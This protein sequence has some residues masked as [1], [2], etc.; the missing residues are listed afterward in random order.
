MHPF[1]LVLPPMV[2]HLDAVDVGLHADRLVPR[3]RHV[4]VRQLRDLG[5]IALLR[6]DLCG[7]PIRDEETLRH[8]LDR[9]DH[10]CTSPCASDAWLCAALVGFRTR[11][12]VG[13]CASQP[14]PKWR[15]EQLLILNTTLVSTDDELV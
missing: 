7:H 14:E 13:R 8:Q 6:G 9:L 4:V 5:S 1:T 3:L 15:S 10:R 11:A 2:A 12:H